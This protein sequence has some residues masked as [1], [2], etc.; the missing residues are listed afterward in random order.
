MLRFI[1]CEVVSSREQAAVW[2][3]HS[4]CGTGFRAVMLAQELLLVWAPLPLP[5]HPC[6]LSLNPVAPPCAALRP[7][8]PQG[9]MLEHVRRQLAGFDN[10][11]ATKSEEGYLE[12]YGGE[13]EAL[14]Y[15]TADS[16]N[17]IT[18]VGSASAPSFPLVCATGPALHCPALAH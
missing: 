5:A 7:P 3:L 10:W 9:S 18:E 12:H 14:V 11:L 8:A 4:A 6:T 1:Y 15:L 2:T 16:P 17:E 13:K